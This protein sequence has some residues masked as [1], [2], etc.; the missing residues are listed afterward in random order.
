MADAGIPTD[1]ARAAG[2]FDIGFLCLF[3]GDEVLES[4][5]DFC[6]LNFTT[7]RGW[8]TFTCHVGCLRERAHEPENFPDIEGDTDEGGEE[9]DED[10]AL[11]AAWTELAETLSQL[12]FAELGDADEVRSLTKALDE[13]ARRH[14]VTIEHD[15]WEG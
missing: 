8:G 7:G 3:C 6:T 15:A 13:A 9:H 11:V 4:A 5:P 1:E 10:P 2:D 14:G 12:D